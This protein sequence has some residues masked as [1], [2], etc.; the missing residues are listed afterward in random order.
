MIGIVV[1][2]HR[3]NTDNRL[4]NSCRW[5]NGSTAATSAATSTCSHGKASAQQDENTQSR[6]YSF[7]SFQMHYFPL[8]TNTVSKRPQNSELSPKRAIAMP[9][10][11]I[12]EQKDL[13]A[14]SIFKPILSTSQHF[15]QQMPTDRAF[16][17][18]EI[19]S[20]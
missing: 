14:D 18:K 15:T 8:R 6:G 3:S 5:A 16:A 19:K 17:R 13:K 2:I 10:T 4:C 20:A 11:E 1:F 9:L 12:F 7:V